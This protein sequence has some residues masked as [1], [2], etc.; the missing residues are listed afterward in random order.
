M[1]ASALHHL[2]CNGPVSSALALPNLNR[3]VHRKDSYFTFGFAAA[4]GR[5]ASLTAATTLD[6]Y[7]LRL[8]AHARLVPSSAPRRVQCDNACRQR[9]IVSRPRQRAGSTGADRI[10]SGLLEM[11]ILLRELQIVPVAVSCRLSTSPAGD[12]SLRPMR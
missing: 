10:S 1:V 2:G 5:P 8:L 7:L 6:K 11:Q 9:G 12:H 3:S 4:F